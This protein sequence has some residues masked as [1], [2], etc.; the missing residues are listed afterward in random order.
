MVHADAEFHIHC[1]KDNAKDLS[2]SG[3]SIL[4]IR[5]NY[6]SSS[7]TVYNVDLFNTNY[8]YNDSTGSEKPEQII[9]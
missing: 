3:S 9:S 5:Y 2:G 1:L 4:K 8:K 7:I 6:I